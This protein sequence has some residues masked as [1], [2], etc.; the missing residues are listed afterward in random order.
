MVARIGFFMLIVLLCSCQE[1][2][3]TLDNYRS[4]RKV[5]THVH[6]DSKDS[7]LALLAREDNFFLLT[8]NVDVPRMDIYA[9]E[10]F[11]LQQ[12]RN[13][14]EQVKY[15][16]TF[17]LEDWNSP[18]WADSAISKLA[19]S[20]GQGALGVK[21]WKNIGMV[22]R[23]SSGKFVMIDDPRFDPLIKYIIA[24]DKTLLGHLGEPKN[25][26]LPIEKMTVNNDKH[27]FKE[28]PEYHMFLHPEYPSYDEQINARDRFLERYPDLRFVG[29]HLGSLEWDV[30]ELA[31]RLDRFPSMAVDMAARICH[32]QYQSM[33]DRDKVRDFIIQ[34][35]DRLIYATDSG[36]SEGSNGQ[37]VKDDLHKRW[38]QDWKYFVSDE[39][40]SVSEVDGQ[41]QGL[42]LPRTVVNKIYYENAVRW[43]QIP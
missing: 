16:T 25:C 27:Y 39:T 9:Q 26:W 42:N 34:Y 18:S 6:L 28:H 14:P 31:K 2:F 1:K 5:D 33:L 38:T 40:M 35:Q 30:H 4:V 29:A 19:R 24:N 8:V 15:V 13:S 22:H 36:I 12:I 21:M 32:L 20:F 10:K 23:D 17:S 11:A 41:F 37:R 7:A 43:F 3:Y